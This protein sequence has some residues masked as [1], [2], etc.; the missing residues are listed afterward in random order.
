MQYWRYG[1]AVV[2]G[3]VAAA[4]GV[5]Q[6]DLTGN[7]EALAEPSEQAGAPAIAA[8]DEYQLS[9][10]ADGVVTEAEVR[11][12]LG[13]AARCMAEQGVEALP[14]DHP[15]LEGNLVL[16][17]RV[18]DGED[19]AADAPVMPECA[20]R[21]SAHVTSAYRAQQRAAG[22]DTPPPAPPGAAMA[23]R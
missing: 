1:T 17:R 20:E 3:I 22:L 9:A 23:A 11:E 10:L 4:F 6:F 19:P 14:L 2:L 21:F 5:S 16:A 12:A 7:R 18:P 15:Q 8:P 13:R